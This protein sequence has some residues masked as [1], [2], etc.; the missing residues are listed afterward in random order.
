MNLIG[1]D[2]RK[3]KALDDVEDQIGWVCPGR[4]T[5]RSAAQLREGGTQDHLLPGQGR[6]ASMYPGRS[7][8]VANYARPATP[9]KSLVVL[10]AGKRSNYTMRS[11]A[12]LG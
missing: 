3:E 12:P 4:L 5:V 1:S 10:P 6:H 8:R 11:I 9:A 7:R 2:N